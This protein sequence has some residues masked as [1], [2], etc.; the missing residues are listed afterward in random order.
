VAAD[1]LK[2]EKP[3]HTLVERPKT[4]IQEKPVHTH[5]DG[6]DVERPKTAIHKSACRESLETTL[7][8]IDKC[9]S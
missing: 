5:V 1:K 6:E 9:G 8:R 4:A 3:V 2:Q 7:M